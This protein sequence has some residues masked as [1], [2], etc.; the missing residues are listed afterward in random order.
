ME[1]HRVASFH[2][3]RE[4]RGRALAALARLGTDR[5]RLAR[6]GGPVFW[7]VL[8]TGRGSDTSVG[9]D[10]RRTAL[11]ALWDD[12]GAL[13]TFLARSPIARRWRDADEAYTVRLRRLGGHG[14]WRGVEILEGMAD[15][16][17]A[18]TGVTPAARA[19]KPPEDRSAAASQ[20]EAVGAEPGQRGHRV[21]SF[22]L[23]RERPG[24][25]VAVHRSPSWQGGP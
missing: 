14:R 5:L 22:H 7:R 8:G 16:T 25:A 10:P 21:A 3:V 20:A 9:V 24:R 23:V 4:R 17:D 19:E 18:D 11:F 6:D 2:L 1:G 13:D 15:V 12:D